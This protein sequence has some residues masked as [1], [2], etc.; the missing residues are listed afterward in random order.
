MV[1]KINCNSSNELTSAYTTITSEIPRYFTNHQKWQIRCDVDPSTGSPLFYVRDGFGISYG[2]TEFIVENLDPQFINELNRHSP[3]DQRQ[4]LI[5]EYLQ[6][7]LRQADRYQ[8]HIEQYGEKKFIRFGDYGLKGGGK[9]KALALL[10]ST[11]LVGAGI[12]VSGFFGNKGKLVGGILI[13]SGLSSGRSACDQDENDNTYWEE[14]RKQIGLGAITGTLASFVSY[15]TE[16]L[17]RRADILT[18]TITQFGSQILKG[19]IQIL[20]G[21]VQSTASTIAITFIEE[22]QLPEARKVA[23]SAVGGLI[24]AS[25]STTA[26]AIMHPV[27]GERVSKA[28]AKALRG[29]M[30]GAAG[31]SCSKAITNFF[32]S[33]AIGSGV[34][35]EGIFNGIVNG[36]IIGLEQL[37]KL[38]AAHN[39]QNRQ[40]QTE[41]D[42]KTAQ[43]EA[44]KNRHETEIVKQNLQR[45]EQELIAGQQ[46]MQQLHQ[47]LQEQ[48]QA[49]RQAQQEVQQAEQMVV[50]AKKVATA[51][52]EQLAA[53][54][55]TLH[56][57]EQKYRD[58]RYLKT[59]K[60]IKDT[61]LH[62]KKIERKTG[63]S[64]IAR[65]RE[66][67]KSALL[68]QQSQTQRHRGQAQQQAQ[69]LQNA[70]EQ[71]RTAL[72]LEQDRL[73]QQQKISRD[74]H[75][76]QESIEK[77]ES[78][79]THLKEQLAKTQVKLQAALEKQ[80][81][82]ETALKN[83][84]AAVQAAQNA[85]Q[86]LCQEQDCIG[87][88][89][90]GNKSQPVSYV[91]CDMDELISH[92]VLVHAICQDTILHYPNYKYDKFNNDQS[93]NDPSQ[94]QNYIALFLV[95]NALTPN[96][97]VGSHLQLEKRKLSAEFASRPQIH[98]AWNQLVQP[99]SGAPGEGWEEATVAILETLSAFENSHP[100]KPFAVAPY[101]TQTFGSVRLSEKTTLLVPA[102]IVSETRKHLNS[103]TGFKGQI[104][105]YDP[106]KK[107]RTAVMEALVAH[108]PETWHVCDPNGR[109]LG[110]TARKTTTGYE[111]KTCLKTAK[112]EVHILLHE[113]GLSPEEQPSQ[114]MQN[115][116]SRAKRFIGLHI[117][118]T[119]AWLEKK[120]YFL[121]LKVFTNNKAVLKNCP[122]FAAHVT[123]IGRLSAEEALKMFKDVLKALKGYEYLLKDV[124]PRA[125]C[126]TAGVLEAFDF[127]QKLI[128]GSNP[129][130]GCCIVANYVLKEAISA[131][132]ASL[133]FQK[134]PEDTFKLSALDLQIIVA[135]IL[136]TVTKLLNRIKE[137][138]DK[139]PKQAFALFTEYCALL[140]ECLTDI[141]QAK[142]EAAYGLSK[143]EDSQIEERIEIDFT[144]AQREWD[145]IKVPDNVEFDLRNSWPLESPLN[146][147]VDK[148]VRLLPSNTDGLKQL[149]HQLSLSRPALNGLEGKKE[150]YR[151][152]VLCSVIQEVLQEKI[153]LSL[154]KIST[155]S[156]LAA[157]LA[158][159]EEWLRDYQ[160]EIRDYTQK[161]G[162]CLFDNFIAQASDLSS[163]TANELRQ[164][165]VSFMRA[166]PIE[167]QSK[168]EYQ[169]QNFLEIGD[170][171]EALLF[172]GWESYLGCVAQPQVWATELE[173]NALSTLLQR[174]I[175][176][177]SVGALPKIY[178]SNGPNPPIFLNHKNWNHFE[179]CVSSNPAALMKT[180]QKILEEPHY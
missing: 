86:E 3:P 137:Q 110:Q 145:Q 139:D 19:S 119:T 116:R 15:G 30:Q 87:V 99:N 32:E 40:R 51:T 162:D 156:P 75:T 136:P 33:K 141:R 23:Y 101:D 144:H 50:Q 49:V 88:F 53:A 63:H 36:S 146:D 142:Q 18:H 14:Y 60:R 74:M 157:G 103:E 151:L 127:Y 115:Y 43:T 154:R 176:L 167:Y 4:R 39:Q 173:I 11:G 27:I 17:T 174:P 28:T 117:H 67:I 31:S 16:F 82:H 55:N 133:S 148:I 122:V 152:N 80:S 95:E 180:Y 68:E 13:S 7:R 164:D 29:A 138:A 109:L 85:Y 12:I 73:S 66:K 179:S 1:L 69:V 100:H 140:K 25:A 54:Q 175:V 38:Q 81:S 177:L 84:Q 61:F 107:L 8:V 2:V 113:E 132:L 22:G 48:Q 104:V 9:N 78:H 126:W 59:S 120:P 130:T 92:V 102:A 149:Y 129:Q 58:V 37:V 169:K 41:N 150:H 93:D 123:T 108:Y 163:K 106:S 96:G 118:S 134:Y 165:V 45:V 71:K 56:A 98:W 5:Q 135:S 6:K 143:V 159:H 72:T 10:A 46:K 161:I 124:N 89:G 166:N 97:T 178:N 20:A 64:S 168:P 94:L 131:D 171:A 35:Q 158:R 91:D 121:L 79:V 44:E 47:N 160:L 65:Q 111:N 77:Q 62:G 170:G 114:A 26:G 153:Y 42:L 24:G 172:D 52:H 105:G 70:L 83:Q 34:L 57:A 21:P 112:G 147:Y 128:E 90:I 76:N 155:I 125:G